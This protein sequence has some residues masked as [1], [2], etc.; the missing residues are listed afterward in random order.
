MELV[1]FLVVVLIAGAT[2][3]A[4]LRRPRAASRQGTRTG[5][6]EAAR[7]AKLREINDAELDHR[8]GKL[9]DE[10]YAIVDGALRAEAAELLRDLEAA[11]VEERQP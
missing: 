7:D 9:S 10:D 3:T 4:P 6:L 1:V 5:A 8:T 11:H 2:V